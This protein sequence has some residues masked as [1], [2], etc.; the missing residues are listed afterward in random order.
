MK[1]LVTTKVAG[2][3]TERATR[4]RGMSTRFD[5]WPEV[6]GERRRAGFS[7]L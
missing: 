1:S 7:V 3:Y 4:S 6:V 5:P 2:T